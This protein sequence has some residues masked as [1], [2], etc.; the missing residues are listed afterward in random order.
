MMPELGR[1]LRHEEG[2]AL[3]RRWIDELEGD[4][5]EAAGGGSR[6]RA[7]ARLSDG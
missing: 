2:L 4:G 6:A 5:C 1:D 7:V 3:I